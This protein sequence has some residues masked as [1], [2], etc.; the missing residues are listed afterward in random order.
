MERNIKI[1]YILTALKNSWFWLGIWVFYYLLFTNY[2]GIGIVETGLIVG[3][4]LGEIPTG[5]IADLLGKKKTLMISFLLMAAGL[6]GVGLT[7]NF[8]W[9]ALWVFIAGVGNSFYS[10]T[11]EALVYDSLKEVKKESN[12]P[13]V[14]SQ[15]GS[16]QLIAP[17][18]AGVIGGFLYYFSPR[19]PFLLHGLFY[20]FGL[21]LCF[22]LIEPYIDSEKFSIN[23][24]INQ[25][26]QGF[27]EL[28]KTVDIRSQT[29][30]LLTIGG[31]VV[32]ADEMINGFLGVEFGFN[33][34]M[35]GILWAV[36]YVLSSF[37]SQL[38]P[39]L[40]KYFDENK[41]LL[42][43]GVLTGISFIVSPYLG[44]LFG[45]FSLLMRSSFQVVFIN[46]ASI[47]INKNTE[48]KYRATTLSTFNMLKNTPYVLFAFFIGSLADKYSARWIAFW[49]G[50][51]L[52]G[53]LLFQII[54]RKRFSAN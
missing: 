32:I 8:L 53:L 45:G 43:I 6:F 23:N 20:F 9:L 42:I 14:I 2:A 27:R 17:A 49:L 12:Y 29:V 50:I 15:I 5:A 44:L 48:S 31:I 30:L 46:L 35:A 37:A 22:F 13:K 39:R 16:L 51:I 38:T 7:P 47:S 28:T 4:T 41:S 10:G 40:L 21:L 52:L 25:T 3:M 33:E 24:F 54:R 36:I 18:I 1:A 26:K 34:Q 19:L 11:L